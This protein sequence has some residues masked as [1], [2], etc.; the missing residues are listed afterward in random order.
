[1]IKTKGGLSAGQAHKGRKKARGKKTGGPGKQS[2]TGRYLVQPDVNEVHIGLRD[3]LK[4]AQPV[5]AIFRAFC[6]ELPKSS[7]CMHSILASIICNERG[8]YRANRN[9]G[10]TIWVYIHLREYFTY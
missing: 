4:G 5:H 9:T 10:H 2:L 1:I 7:Q 3:S 6:D 8:I